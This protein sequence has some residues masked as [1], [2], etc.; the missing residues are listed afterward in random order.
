MKKGG[1]TKSSKI[2]V[3]IRQKVG[4][5]NKKTGTGKEKKTRS[6]NEKA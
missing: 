3:N 5:R 4:K 2:L 1:V 6:S